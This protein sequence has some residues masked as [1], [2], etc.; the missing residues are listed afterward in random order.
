MHSTP[1]LKKKKKRLDV[2]VPSLLLALSKAEV[3][4]QTGLCS[5]FHASQAYIGATVKIK[6]VWRM[7]VYKVS[8]QFS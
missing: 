3:Q 1:R 4:S 6:G 2:H 5:K 7:E 8:S